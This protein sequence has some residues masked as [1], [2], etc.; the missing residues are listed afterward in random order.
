MIEDIHAFLE[1]LPKK[2]PDGEIPLLTYT[3][4]CLES[5]MSYGGEWVYSNWMP[6]REAA[7][8]VFNFSRINRG[9]IISLQA[10]GTCLQ[11]ET[12]MMCVHRGPG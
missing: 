2:I 10:V 8:Q 6:T 5:R 7:C 11:N 4:Y 12:I 1:K 9:W 3:A